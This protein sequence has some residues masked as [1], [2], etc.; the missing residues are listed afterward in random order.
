MIQWSLLDGE[1]KISPGQELNFVFFVTKRDFFRAFAFEGQFCSRFHFQIPI[2][3]VCIGGTFEA[4][5]AFSPFH[6]SFSLGDTLETMR[7]RR[8]VARRHF[9]VAEGIWVQM[10]LKIVHFWMKINIL[11][12]SPS[13]YKR[14][15]CKGL[16]DGVLIE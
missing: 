16:W 12:S 5:P 9:Q 14:M 10:G 2:A 8:G 3:F 6:I 1:T 13:Q 15:D 11:E 7:G 4:T